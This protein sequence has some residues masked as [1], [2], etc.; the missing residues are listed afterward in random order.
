[1]RGLTADDLAEASALLLREAQNN[2]GMAMIYGLVAVLQDWLQ[3]KVRR[4]AS[5]S[6]TRQA[7]DPPPWPIRPGH[8]LFPVIG[9]SGRFCPG[10]RCL[11]SAVDGLCGMLTCSED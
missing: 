9:T 10:V 6:S 11:C 2:L 3:T 4:P 8:I 1:M 7:C 5:C